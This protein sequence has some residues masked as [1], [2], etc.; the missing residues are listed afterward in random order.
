MKLNRFFMLGL[1]GLAFAACSNEEEV[2]NQLPNGTGAVTVKIAAPMVTKGE[3]TG[4]SGNSVLVVPKSGSKV[5]ITLVADTGGGTIEIEA[6]DEWNNQEK[7]V[8]FWGVKNPTSV[9]VTMNGGKQTYSSTNV[10]DATLLNIDPVNIPAYGYTTDITLT[11]N[12]SSP[13]TTDKDANHQYGATTENNNTTYQMYTATVNMAIPVARLEISGIKHITTDGHL[14]TDC[15]YSKLTI[16]GV[17]LDNLYAEGTGVTY[18]NGAFSCSS[19]DLVDYSFTGQTDPNEDDYSGT[20]DGAASPLKDAI[21]EENKN[22]LA[23]DA[24]WPTTGVYAYNF[25]GATGI[26]NL[27][28]FKIYFSEAVSADPT[29]NPKSTPRYAMI[30][31]Y[32]TAENG[33]E[34][35]TEFRPGTIYRI[36]GATLTDE[37]IIGDEGGNTLYGVEV[38][39][40]EAQWA[41]QTIYA[42]WAQ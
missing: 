11:A 22:F 35:I 31:S 38:T 34:V 37:N 6:G 42:D 2:G 18:S 23:P 19:G 32:K 25:F 20:T 26:D 8:V 5:S 36:I 16:E 41:V 12:T 39:V 7:E 1:A 15:E 10:D 29:N 17:Y 9:E 24:V 30:T 33:G 40:E 4:T 13:A 3:A 14:A 21:A 28:K 27:P